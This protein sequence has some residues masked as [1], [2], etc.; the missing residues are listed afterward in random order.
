MPQDELWAC[1]ARITGYRV[2]YQFDVEGG[3][4]DLFLM[5]PTWSK[6]PSRE[7]D[8]GVSATVPTFMRWYMPAV[9]RVAHDE[10]LGGV[11][12]NLP[13]VVRRELRLIQDD[14]QAGAVH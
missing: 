1:S 10:L 7:K 9:F 3:E 8:C 13:G 4:K 11:A 14:F 2:H 12:R 6:H 5:T